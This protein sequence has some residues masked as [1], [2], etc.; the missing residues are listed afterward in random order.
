[1]CPSLHSQKGGALSFQIGTLYYQGD[2]APKPTNFSFGQGNLSWGIG[3]V[4]TFNPWF[5]TSFGYLEGQISGDDAFAN[6]DGRRLRNLHFRS[7]IKEYSIQNYFLLNTILKS[8]DKYKISLYYTVGIGYFT[9]NPMTQYNNEW[10]SLK[11]L[12]TEGQYLEGSMLAPYALH[13]LNFLFGFNVEFQLYKGCNIGL[14]LTPRRTFTDY[15]DDVST[16]YPDKVALLDQGYTL[17]AIL[18][19]RSLQSGVP[20]NNTKNGA[21]R[22]DSKNNDWYTHMGIYIKKSLW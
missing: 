9:F 5:S 21:P 16:I 18:T 19:D 12:G 14:S 17:A 13:G 22:G 3:Y 2:L 7:P 8:L 1:M 11:D 10:I 6:T 15:L 20:T 4:H